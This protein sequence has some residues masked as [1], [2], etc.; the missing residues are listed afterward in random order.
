MT[1]EELIGHLADY[2]D[3]ELI[4]EKRHLFELHLCGCPNCVVFLETYTFTVKVGKKLPKTGPLPDRLKA[5]LE[6]V[7]KEH[8]EKAT[9]G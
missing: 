6:K 1:C 5:R 2:L 7:L 4:V 9:G 3:G 8:L